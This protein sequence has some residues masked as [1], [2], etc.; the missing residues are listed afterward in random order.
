MESSRHWRMGKVLR[1]SLNRHCLGHIVAAGVTM[2]FALSMFAQPPRGPRVLPPGPMLDGG[3]ATLDS[4]ALH[5]TLLKYSG[6]VAELRPKADPTL[7][8]T[9]G[10]RLKERSADTF[11]HLGDLDL[12]IR[13]AGY[14]EWTDVSTAFHRE[15]A[16]VVDSS[17]SQFTTDA[18]SSLPAGTPLKLVKTWSVDKDD[19]VL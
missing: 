10:D 5:L 8:Y 12:R 16:T 13:A 4:T 3:T 19:L 2:T 11:Y 6:T 9:P 18:S 1:P 14:A 7:D 15:P 17:G